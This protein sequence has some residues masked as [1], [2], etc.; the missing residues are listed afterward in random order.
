AATTGTVTCPLGQVSIG[1]G[2]RGAPDFGVN[3]TG[4]YPDVDPRTWNV[5][6]YNGSGATTVT[7]YAVCIDAPA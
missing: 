3:V 5:S 4:S 6:L 1:G 2:F 7:I